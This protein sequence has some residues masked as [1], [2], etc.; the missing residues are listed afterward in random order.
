MY[1]LKPH[2]SLLKELAKKTTPEQQRLFSVNL[3]AEE[4]RILVEICYNLLKGNIRLTTGQTTYFKKFAQSI[5][6]LAR[7]RSGP[8]AR[9]VLQEG[10]LPLAT[11][12]SIVLSEIAPYLLQ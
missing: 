11:I 7:Q 3:S 5:R 10:G 12:A 4:V 2:I 1:F 9:K 8:S 6:K